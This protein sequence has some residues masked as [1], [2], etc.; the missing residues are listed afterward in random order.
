MSKIK[1]VKAREVIDSRGN[2]T[3]E[4]D[5]TLSNGAFVEQQ[6]LPGHQPGNLKPQSFAMGIRRDFWENEF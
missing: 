2:P 1:V 5:V 3:V 6:F 4:V